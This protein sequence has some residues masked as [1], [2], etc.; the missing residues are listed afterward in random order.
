M[1]GEDAFLA[2]L[3][4]ARRWR[5]EGER[6]VIEGEGARLLLTPAAEAKPQR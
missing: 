5:L 2:A 6:L 1:A 3:T 4:S